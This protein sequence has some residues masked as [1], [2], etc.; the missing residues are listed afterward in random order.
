MIDDL[1]AQR[2]RDDDL[3]DR[4]LLGIVLSTA[5]PDSGQYLTDRNIRYQILTFLAADHETTSGALSFALCYL[6]RSPRARAE[7]QAET[8]AI[9]GTDPDA[10]PTFEQVAKF[11]H[12]RCAFDEALRLWPT[13]PAFTRS[14]NTDTVIGDRHPLR[15]QDWAI[16][17]IPFI[18]R[19]PS[20]RGETDA[21]LGTDPDLEPTFKQVPKFRHIRRVLEEALRFWPT[22]PVFTRSPNADTVIGD[23]YP[24]RTQ[25]WATVLIPLIHRDPWVWGEDAEKF[26]PNR[27]LPENSRGRAPH[28]YE[29]FGTGERACIGRQFALHTAV[30]VLARILNRY[31]LTEDSEYELAISERLTLMPKGFEVVLAQRTPTV[32]MP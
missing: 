26:R 9:L 11:R 6:C 31:D 15:P 21:I 24:M 30:L 17:L 29:P 14:P 1:I 16:I 4:D 28:S 8:D 12:T 25:D 7:A 2:R 32:S 19:D 20:V 23:R 5:H 13:A 10:E 27:F 18:H 3:E 22:A